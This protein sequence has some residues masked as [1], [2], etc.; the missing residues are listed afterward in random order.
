MDG[1]VEA[2]AG[3]SLLTL[4]RL[5]RGYRLLYG[6]VLVFFVAG[7]VVGLVHHAVQAG[8]TPD[9]TA[10]WWLGNAGDADATRLLFAKDPHLVLD[11][12]WRRSLAN[13]IP[14]VVILA[15]AFRSSLSGRAF[16]ALA[17]VLVGTALVDLAAPALV[18][19]GGRV[20]G[21]PALA[22]RIGLVASVAVSAAVCWRDM[23]LRPEAG[24]RFRKRIGK[25]A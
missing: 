11:A 1:D 5:S 20:W 22:A 9:A 24:P 21:A 13:V 16:G 15:L 25:P 8:L 17:A 2:G 18:R 23:W 19:W 7:H 6:G 4:R 14:T 10:D 3:R 12:I